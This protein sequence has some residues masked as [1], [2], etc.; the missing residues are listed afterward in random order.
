MQDKFRILIEKC[1]QVQGIRLLVDSNTGWG[2]FAKE[3]I[4]EAR[5]ELPKSPLVLYSVTGKE[6]EIDFFDQD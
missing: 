2:S 5:D 6:K 3:Y 1:D 4:E